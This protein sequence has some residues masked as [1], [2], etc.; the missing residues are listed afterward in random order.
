[1]EGILETINELCSPSNSCGQQEANQLT[2]MISE[3]TEGELRRK[4]KQQTKNNSPH[5]IKII[6]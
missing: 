1:M 4:E 5:K 2:S 6:S 3:L